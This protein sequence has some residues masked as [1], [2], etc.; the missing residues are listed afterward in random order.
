MN[1]P[2]K[3]TDPRPLVSLTGILK[4]LAESGAASWSLFP[5]ELPDV[6]DPLQD[7]AERTGLVTTVGA[8]AVQAII[9]APFAR[10]RGVPR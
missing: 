4:I 3:I 8:D 6:I 5:L 2:A 10:L 7:F 1:A 9:A